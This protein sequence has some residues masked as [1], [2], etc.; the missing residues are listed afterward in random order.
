MRHATD[1][2]A[3]GQAGLAGLTRLFAEP[4][5]A[6]FHQ[7]FELV[8]LLIDAVGDPFLVEL[9]RGGRGLFDQLPD[10]VLKDRDPIVEF[11]Q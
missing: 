11:G 3:V 5:V 8:I 1:A 10:V 6:L 7:P 9:A 4:G 2:A